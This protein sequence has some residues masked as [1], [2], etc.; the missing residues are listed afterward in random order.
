MFDLIENTVNFFKKY[1]LLDLIK[2]SCKFFLKILTP[3]NIIVI[4]FV[5]PPILIRTFSIDVLYS[6]DTSIL[7][8][9]I[10]DILTW[11][12]NPIYSGA[13]IVLFSREINNEEWTYNQC[14]IAGF[15]F[16][17]NLFI[18][19]LISGALILLGLIALIVPGLILI[20]KFA[21]S[22]FLIVLEGDRPI[23]SLKKSADLAKEYVLPMVGSFLFLFAPFIMVFFIMQGPLSSFFNGNYIATIISDTLLA[24][25]EVL[26]FILFFRF[27][28]F[29]KYQKHNEAIQTDGQGIG[30]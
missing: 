22:D 23:Q 6:S 17:P 5:L 20:A 8:K 28:C 30:A 15:F 21:F 10:P 13:L 27:Y 4:P 19:Y 25:I 14:I 2:D 29:I 24:V 18:A 26:F 7:V 1:I 9:H 16:W 12:L 3:I 11:I